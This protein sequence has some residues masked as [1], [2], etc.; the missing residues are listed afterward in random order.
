M[1]L[2]VPA[3]SARV[4]IG[5]VCHAGGPD[6]L[7]MGVFGSCWR[8]GRS[9]RWRLVLVAGPAGVGKS[10]LGWEFEKYTDGLMEPGVVL[11][12]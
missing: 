2:R 11:A 7:F 8:A 4:A 12:G 6:R 9:W 1:H 3:D 10:R 5:A